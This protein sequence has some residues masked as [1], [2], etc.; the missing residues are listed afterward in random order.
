MISTETIYR[1]CLKTLFWVVAMGFLLPGTVSALD[2][3]AKEIGTG[4][5]V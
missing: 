4:I 3:D 5:E 1:I 2:Q